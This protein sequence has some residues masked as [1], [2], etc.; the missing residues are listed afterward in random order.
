MQ[1]FENIKAKLKQHASQNQ[2]LMLSKEEV[3]YL[4]DTLK[5]IRLIPILDM[6]NEMHRK[7]L[8]DEVQK[9]KKSES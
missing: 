4:A 3:A 8:F 6:N 1:A 2:G 5:D 7:Q 9:N